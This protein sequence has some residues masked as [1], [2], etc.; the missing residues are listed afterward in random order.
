[1]DI[2]RI[3]DLYLNGISAA[4]QLMRSGLGKQ[5]KKCQLFCIFPTYTMVKKHLREYY[6]LRVN[7]NG[8][9]PTCSTQVIQLLNAFRMELVKTNFNRS[10]I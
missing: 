9:L 5:A 2:G 7:V 8:L 4:V 10:T 1:M 3:S 6:I